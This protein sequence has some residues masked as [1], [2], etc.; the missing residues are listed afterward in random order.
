MSRSIK[1]PY[2]KTPKDK[3]SYWRKIRRVGKNLLKLGKDIPNNK[4]IVNDYEY[5]GANITS[6]N[7]KDKIRK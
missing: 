5:G 1:K 3:E 4:E 2:V 6:S 7:P